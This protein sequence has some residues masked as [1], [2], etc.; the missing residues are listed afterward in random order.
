MP[1]RDL[2]HDLTQAISIAPIALA[3]VAT[4]NGTGVDTTG[5]EGVMLSVASGVQGGTSPVLTL[6]LQ[7]SA[8]NSS[9]NAVPDAQVIAASGLNSTGFIIAASTLIELGYIGAK[10]YVRA[11]LA[12]AGT[13][14]TAV[15][16][17]IV[18]EGHARNLPA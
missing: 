14:P 3:A 17:A 16:S 11:S 6:T 4:T 13:S 9:W 12:L 10:R 5:Y 8:D 15:V 18:V 1:T 2:A 7:E